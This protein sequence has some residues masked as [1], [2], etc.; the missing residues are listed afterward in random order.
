MSQYLTNKIVVIVESGTAFSSDVNSKEVELDN[1]Q[2]AKVVIR[3]GAGEEKDTIAKIVAVLP[4]NSEVKIREESIKIGNNT[5]TI[6]NIVA[7]ELAHYDSKK[8]KININI[9]IN[10]MSALRYHNAIHYPSK[11]VYRYNSNY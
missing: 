11:L 5:E 2:S 3:T 7:N 6:I 4:D 8:F 9:S 10:L 1:Y